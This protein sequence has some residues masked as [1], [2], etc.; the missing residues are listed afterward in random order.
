MHQKNSFEKILERISSEELSI[1]NV[2]KN[3]MSYID[4]IKNK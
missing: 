3:F 1:N 4:V 2:I